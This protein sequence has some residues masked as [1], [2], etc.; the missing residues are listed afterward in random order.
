[1]LHRHVRGHAGILGNE[2]A[3]RLAFLASLDFSSPS[4]RCL[5]EWPHLLSRHPLP[6]WTWLLLGRSADLPA[7]MALQGESMRLQQQVRPAPPPPDD[8]GTAVTLQPSAVHLRFLSF[9]V[10]SLCE[11][12]DSR[13]T[14]R[15]VSSTAQGMKVVG[16]RDL[17]K[18][19]FGRLPAL[20]VGLQETRLLH[21]AVAPDDKFIMLHAACTIAGQLGVG[22]WIAKDVSYSREGHKPRYIATEHLH[23]HSTSPRHLLAVVEAPGLRLA[24]LVAHGPF[25]GSCHDDPETFWHRMS[26][27]LALPGIPADVAVLMHRSQRACRLCRKRICQQS[28]RRSGDERRG[29][30]PLLFVAACLVCPQHL[31]G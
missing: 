17:L 10:L 11:A 1:M 29:A 19:Q 6:E 24:I 2:I 31:S 9:N 14:A 30:L 27:I 21:T 7:L 25:D 5:P 15:T 20:F 12:D 28:W 23:V 13:L 16:K 3:D 4:S 26:D 22:L 18:G 8:G